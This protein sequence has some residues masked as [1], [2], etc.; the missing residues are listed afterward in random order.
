MLPFRYS[1][2]VK[3]AYEIVEDSDKGAIV[4]YHV[5]PEADH[6]PGFPYP[7]G[8]PLAPKEYIFPP[9]ES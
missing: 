7:V 8:H 2:H 5:E 1:T 4:F 9:L 3:D 6:P